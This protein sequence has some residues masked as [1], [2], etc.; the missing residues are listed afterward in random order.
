M[1]LEGVEI[2]ERLVSA[3]TNGDLVLFVGAGASVDEP[4]GLPTFHGL[5]KRLAE[6]SQKQPP[7]DGE[8]LDKA[9]GSLKMSGVDVHLKVREIIGDP[10]SKPNELHRAIGSLALA[11]PKPKIITTNYD[12][13]LS[14]CLEEG[15][16]E[17]PSMAFP[18]RED[19]TGIVY[20]H[21]STKELPENLVVTD[22]DFGSV[23]LEAPWTA[24]QFLSRVFRAHTVLF[25]GY[26][27]EDTLME[28]LAR[29]LPPES[30]RYAFCLDEPDQDERWRDFGIQPI[31]YPS[32]K[33]LPQLIGKWVERA[34]MGILD[35][36]RR[37]KN[38][39]S[40]TPPL[41]REDESYMDETM[42]SPERLRLFTENARGV[43]W[44]RWI[45]DRPEFKRI[46]DPLAE[47][48]QPDHLA[49]W[50][51]EHY[52]ARPETLDEA[53][54]VF[55]N[56]GGQFNRHLL[57]EMAW[58]VRT[59]LDS[60]E[61]E[62]E[63]AKIW[64]PLL[65]NQAPAHVGGDLL[66]ILD[67]CDPVKD[68]HETLLLFDH[69]LMPKAAL[70]QF[71]YGTNGMR[72]EPHL[73]G[74]SQ[75]FDH[76]LGEYWQNKL[77]PSLTEESL[78]I[79]VAIIADQHIRTAHRIAAANGN[80]ESE[81]IRLSFTRSAVED[82]EQNR[83]SRHEGLSLLID[84]A[85]DT[86][87]ALLEH[88]PEHAEHYLTSWGESSAPLMRRLAIHGWTERN[89]ATP[90]EKID[91]LRGTG[92]LSDIYL[93][94]ESMRLLARTLPG[95]SQECVGAL[96]LD[97]QIE[98]QEKLDQDRQERD[99]M[100]AQSSDERTAYN[101]LEW[102][103][104]YAP[105]VE[106][107]QEAFNAV[108]AQHPGWLPSDHPDFL[109]WSGPG[110]WLPQKRLD[111]DELHL[112]LQKDPVDA[113]NHLTSLREYKDAHSDEMN[114]DEGLNS[115][116]ATVQ[117]YPTD[118]VTVIDL[119]VDNDA[120]SDA[121]TRQR[122]AQAVLS[123][124]THVDIN[125]VLCDA[126]T[127]RLDR[128]WA[129]GTNEWIQKS[130]TFGSDVDWLTH[131]FNHWGGE[132]A[133]V[134]LQLIDFEYHKAG[135]GWIGLPEPLK[136]V[137]AAMIT[138]NDDPSALAQAILAG[139]VRYLFAVDEQWCLS[140][141]LPLLDP[142]ID[143]RRA[144]RCWD[145]YL[146]AG[147]TNQAMLEAGHLDYYLKMV[148][149][150]DQ[151]S[152][153]SRHDYFGHLAAIALFSGMNPIEQGWL[154]RFT[155]T[156]E[157]KA[158]THWIGAIASDLT[159]L[160]GDAADAQW[161]RWMRTYWEN[162][163][164]S[165]PKAMTKDE[166]ASLT[167]WAFCLDNRFPEAVEL[168]CQHSAP[169]DQADNNLDWILGRIYHHSDNTDHVEAHP[170]ETTILLTHILSS[171]KALP[172]Q[173]QSIL[174]YRLDEMV[175]ALLSNLA[176]QQSTSLREQAVRLGIATSSG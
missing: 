23:Y 121:A 62:G 106:A 169:V 108:Q 135:D 107:A 110:E 94:H 117:A 93:R 85:R 132:F 168:A 25:I 10:A 104:R 76:L 166:A 91:W 71:S 47:F 70:P 33:V 41:S 74:V 54:S 75:S 98:L 176:P 100:P 133:R 59:A 160:S 30:E 138:G 143:E 158:R 48:V 116:D 97:V 4:S 147:A 68:P 21:G 82:H 32:H 61:D 164:N 66:R 103:A 87:E 22:A 174:R 34:H 154:D 40:G 9:L 31:A 88:H 120:P 29:S 157:I 84:I 19:F 28:Y 102:I 159:E 162:R 50:F 95:A 3:H 49:R 151:I 12:R 96:V 77:Q 45:K 163:L 118:G 134:V 15:V 171:V 20:L 148:S 173:G 119:L 145:A 150:L 86:L 155:A 137:L 136:S 152:E 60:D 38:I 126:I 65:V 46:F 89:D 172:P 111:P 139:R 13:H 92:W 99:E 58:Q 17:F 128:M 24:A 142:E 73:H 129:I 127:Q 109:I 146:T 113:I 51:A 52:A 63:R 90:D 167:S 43:E 36:E 72:L 27:H 35:H 80:V 131:A 140:S 57:Q 122:L 26:S 16:D 78:A 125:D 11:S 42:R 69:L 64:I 37:V 83:P 141:V 6:D 114:R 14:E 170:K 2:P 1:W 81:W 18:Q 165:T 115:L 123:A 56:H 39:V 53:L 156:A 8:A 5:A 112:M 130:D 175:S 67:K 149:R 55:H 124:W 153:H 79:D 105:E 161:D 7:A 44:L 101:L 144:V